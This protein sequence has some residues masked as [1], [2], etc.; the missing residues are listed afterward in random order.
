MALVCFWFGLRC[1]SRNRL[2]ASPSASL[3][4]EKG[5]CLAARLQLVAAPQGST[6]LGHITPSL[7]KLTV[8]SC[9]R[10]SSGRNDSQVGHWGFLT[11]LGANAIPSS[12]WASPVA[13]QSRIRLQC[14]GGRFDPWVRKIP[15][16]RE[17][18][19]PPVFL[20][21]NPMERSLAGYSP[22]GRKSR[23]R[24]SHAYTSSG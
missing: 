1:D 24:L 23:T 17:W 12:G 8:R 11:L 22:Q 15:W 5:V 14:K 20:W 13:Q 4:M 7:R 18:H 2:R 9:K 6:A 10:S 21:E 3:W 16:R 19:P